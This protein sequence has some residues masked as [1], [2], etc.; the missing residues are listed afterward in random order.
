LLLVLLLLLWRYRGVDLRLTGMRISWSSPL[1]D[2]LR[3][4]GE[5][6]LWQDFHEGS[7]LPAALA[8]VQAESFVTT[9]VEA[10]VMGRSFRQRGGPGSVALPDPV[11]AEPGLV[12][13]MRRRRSQQS[14][15]APISLTDLSTVLGQAL[16][17]TLLGRDEA[18]GQPVLRR[19]WP[20]AGGLYPLDFYLLAR[21][22]HQLPQG[23]YHVNL[24]AGQLEPMRSTQPIDEIAR[25]GFFWQDFMLDASAILLV[26]GVFE[27]SCA[28]YGERGYRFTLL[29]AGHA[30]QNVLLVAVQ[31]DLAAVP[32]G[33]FD[34]DG[35]AES[36]GLD[37]INQAVIHTVAL[38]GP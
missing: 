10:F 7:K 17:P 6:A 15:M 16:G 38:G 8:R 23:C 18:T 29:D 12:S 11:P 9:E 33:G 28:K 19:A 14:L 4:L 26:V 3:P 20:S 24:I 32:V 22:V 36:L 34:D 30:A 35:L 21:R 37:G 25:R 2:E 27:R 13:V 31:Q 1:D 5:V